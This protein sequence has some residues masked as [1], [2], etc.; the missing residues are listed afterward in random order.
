MCQ[1]K[2]RSLSAVYMK[3]T[4]KQI[5][6]ISKNSNA[7]KSDQ[8]ATIYSVEEL[9]A[10][11]PNTNPSS[12]KEDFIP[13]NPDLSPAPYREHPIQSYG[14]LTLSANN[15]RFVNGICPVNLSIIFRI[16]WNTNN[17]NNPEFCIHK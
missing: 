3:Q 5:K 14:G 2:A 7:R 12:D 8:L 13:G 9:H 6:H 17:N 4:V 16:S 11:L 10:G 1:F 15:N